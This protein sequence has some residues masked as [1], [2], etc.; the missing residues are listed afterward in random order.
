MSADGDLKVTC[1]VG[2]TFTDV[3]VSGGDAVNIGKALTT[4]HDLVAGLRAA[5]ADVAT[6]MGIELDELLGR[7]ALFVY[8][9]TQAT[10]AILQGT[11]A[12]T[13]L[14]CTEGFP[15]VLVRREGGS[16]H[17][18]DFSRPYPDPYIPRRLTFEIRER[19][20]A[21]GEVVTPLDEEHARGVLRELARLDVD[22]VAIALLW[23]VANGAHEDRLAA[24]CGEL[25][26]DVPVTCS[27]VLNP[28]LREYRRTS[29]AA[30]DA[31]LK[32]LMQ[33]HLGGVEEG[34]RDSGLRGRLVAATS[35]G[36]VLPIEHLAQRPIYAA[37]SGPSLAPIAARL[38]AQREFGAADAVVCDTGG[39]SFD[40]SLVREGS[41]VF[42]RET[43]LGEPF[44]GHHTGLAS[45]DVRSIGSG[46]GSIAWIDRGGLL[47][48]GPD[49]AG[50][51]PG[52]ACYG[53]GGTRPTVTDAAC[54]LGY[55][56]PERFLGGHMRLDEQAAA[57]VLTA[58]GERLG[59][60]AQE[61]ADAVLTLAGEHMVG[62]IREITINQGVD[63]RDLAIVA[64]GGAAGLNIAEIARAL[65]CPRVLIPRT[66]G[67]LSAFGGQYSD[68]VYETGFSLQTD[69]GDYD[70]A[71]LQ[72]AFAAIDARLGV[73]EDS[74]PAGL[75]GV[76]R[77]RFLEARYAHQAWTIEVPLA[78][79]PVD[80]LGD[81]GLIADEFHG[82]HQRL[83]ATS[84]PG[85][86]V[87]ILQCRGRTVARPFTP[88]LGQ[89]AG[90]R[91]AAGSR[92]RRVFFGHTGEVEVD[93]LD[94]GSL[95][96]GT[97]ID[98]PVL[99]TEPTTTVV[100]PPQAR[101]RT[102]QLGSYVL[103]VA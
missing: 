41:P 60:G 6:A 61:A 47:R 72:D 9:T 16:M 14:L 88:V 2:G 58:L 7:T 73:F 44:R 70:F 85:E 78:D 5:L 77:E 45:V 100:V 23:S 79:R 38:Y 25:L 12:R 34:L 86:V 67:A 48:V 62:A 18:Y 37:K 94:G 49:S 10:N 3:V 96:P 15:D 101:L 40:V 19:I 99:V 90:V 33:R 95:A 36:G 74:L 64:G 69:S 30:I 82:L 87:E 29:C 93:V 52:P 43:W 53:R 13:A 84:D 97:Q 66:A 80:E 24:M 59:L 56:D 32:P 98:G 31:S 51:D 1:D 11:T 103:E 57:D 27:H 102:T 4:P 54:V 22:A 71:A 17:P 91:A 42:T 21:D 35:M 92:R 83:F 65:E 81:P 26:P 89:I 46:G 75:E 28:V 63:P 20:G 39:T 50:A 76:H 55:L 8:S 68:I